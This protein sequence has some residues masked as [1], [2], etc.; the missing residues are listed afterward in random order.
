MRTLLL[1]SLLSPSLACHPELGISRRV[2]AP[3]HWLLFL[4]LQSQCLQNLV[5]I[6]QL[7]Q[8]VHLSKNNLAR[9]VSDKSSALADTRNRRA[10]AQDA[11]FARYPSM[12]IEIS[13]ERQ[14]HWADL[15]FPPCAMAGDRINADVQNL[16]IER[17]ELFFPGI[18]FRH[19]RRSSR[20]PIERMKRHN[21]ALLT[22]IVAR[23]DRDPLVSGKREK[24]EIGHGIAGLQHLVSHLATEKIPTPAAGSAKS[25]WHSEHKSAETLV[26]RFYARPEP[27]K[28]TRF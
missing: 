18:E 21:Q 5:Y 7:I 15:S 22:P 25:T 28:F 19:L 3:G 17:R 26:T 20:G 8:G 14:L 6:H 4:L 10:F 23:S 12:W 24:V 27:W 1:A 13:A 11:K 9:P 2:L 16:G